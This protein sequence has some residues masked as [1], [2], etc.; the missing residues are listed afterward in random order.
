MAALK[1]TKTKTET[2]KNCARSRSERP[3][4]PNPWP[5]PWPM[6]LTFHPLRTMVMTYSQAKGQ[7]R[8][9]VGRSIENIQTDRR[10]GGRTDGGDCITRV[11]K[12]VANDF[13]DSTKMSLPGTQCMWPVVA[14]V[15]VAPSCESYVNHSPAR[16][17]PPPWL[18]TSEI[19]PLARR[20]YEHVVT[21]MGKRRFD[22]KETFKLRTNT[23]F[24][25]F[26][27]LAM[28]FYDGC[29]IAIDIDAEK[30]REQRD[31]IAF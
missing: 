1:L 19:R 25:L 31:K 12:A 8:R 27:T 22:R 13:H 21:R 26:R 16:R 17:A 10:T 4:L 15:V 20:M 24:S 30:W 9:S 18:Y 23:P 3:H 5:W 11:A 6:T 28:S 2:I 29:S 7:R 14:V